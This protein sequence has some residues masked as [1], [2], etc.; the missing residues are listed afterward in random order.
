MNL[1]AATNRLTRLATLMLSI[2]AMASQSAVADP[3][4]EQGCYLFSYFRNNGE[5]GLHF[6]S[7]TD[8]LKWES[9]NDDKSFTSPTAGGKLMRDPSI[10]QGPDG[11]FHMVWSSGW[12]D[13]GFGYASSRD[14]IHWSEHRCLDRSQG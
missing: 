10:V 9:L 14:L 6:A 11:V 3:E 13:L 5:D 2:I 12:W 1:R 7:S 4:P 8:G